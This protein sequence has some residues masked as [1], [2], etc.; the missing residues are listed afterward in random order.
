MAYRTNTIRLRERAEQVAHVA[1]VTLSGRGQNARKLN[2]R[3]AF[4]KLDGDEPR[5]R[6]ELFG[7]RSYEP[8]LEYGMESKELCLRLPGT[9]QRKLH[10]WRGC[11]MTRMRMKI[12]SPAESW[13]QG[14]TRI[15][16]VQ[17]LL[18]VL[19]MELDK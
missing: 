12:I 6:P 5:T 11:G 3:R 10:E 4:T 1:V 19:D 15:E 18:G 8:P 7:T 16:P 13:E 14:M 9:L 2:I 17:D